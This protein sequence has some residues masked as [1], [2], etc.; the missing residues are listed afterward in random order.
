MCYPLDVMDIDT[1]LEMLEVIASKTSS[2]IF[3]TVAFGS[4]P[5]E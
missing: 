3:S 5:Y 4:L 1:G 2:L